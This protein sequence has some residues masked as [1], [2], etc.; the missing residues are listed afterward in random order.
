[1]SC[2]WKSTF[3]RKVKQKETEPK[4]LEF[5][6]TKQ[7]QQRTQCISKQWGRG[8][9]EHRQSVP[10]PQKRGLTQNKIKT[11]QKTKTEGKP[12][13]EFTPHCIFDLKDG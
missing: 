5:S 8:R 12:N 6:H 4:R 9:V 2:F 10:V 13:Q 7:Q 1:M 3:F 11:N